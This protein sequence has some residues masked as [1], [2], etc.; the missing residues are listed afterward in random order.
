MAWWDIFVTPE[1][2]QRVAQ[3]RHRQQLTEQQADLHPL[4]MQEAQNQ[5]QAQQFAMQEQQRKSDL[6]QQLEPFA[7]A[8]ALAQAIQNP[9]ATL[10]SPAYQQN[11]QQ[12]FGEYNPAQALQFAHRQQPGVREEAVARGTARGT[13]AGGVS[14]EAAPYGM[15][16]LDFLKM[17]FDQQ[18]RVAGIY[19]G[20]RGGG[21]TT[22]P[23][24]RLLAG[25]QEDLARFNVA[26]QQ[27]GDVTNDLI[28][29][30]PN[31]PAL[32]MQEDTLEGL[33]NSIR[34]AE[35]FQTQLLP[36]EVAGRAGD[37]SASFAPLLGDISMQIQRIRK[38]RDE[39]MATGM[40]SRGYVP[41]GAPE[42]DILGP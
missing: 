14:G 18:A 26:V 4:A 2:R 20:D 16:P 11:I 8:S 19:T 37:V 21:T 3:T 32:Q 35:T 7:Q 36:R 15:S 31:L 40:T 34:R 33:A 1:E 29:G 23:I 9:M 12:G 30:E 10:Q 6:A 39:L 22:A 42:F 38:R 41:E 28:G 17:K 27:Q 13:A 5:L 25:V 24:A